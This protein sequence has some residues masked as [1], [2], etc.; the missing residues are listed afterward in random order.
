MA[1]LIYSLC[2]LTCLAAAVL[3]LRAWQRSR[4]ALLFW[5]GLCFIFLATSNGLLALDRIFLDDTDLS[6]A[7]FASAFIGLLLLV[8]GLIMEGD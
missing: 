1:A 4:L 6:T 3:L 7:R 5:S 8:Y 2:T